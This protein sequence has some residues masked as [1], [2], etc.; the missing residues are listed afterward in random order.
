MKR[1][2]W[3]FLLIPI[4]RSLA[5]ENKCLTPKLDEW[6]EFSFYHMSFFC[7]L[8]RKRNYMSPNTK[9]ILIMK[10]TLFQLN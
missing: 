6:L 8:T 4:L 10:R 2:A 7:D 3:L 9:F 1:S 5:K